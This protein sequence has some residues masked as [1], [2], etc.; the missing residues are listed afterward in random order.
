MSKDNRWKIVTVSAPG[1]V[2]MSILGNVQLGL[3]HP[4]N[5]GPSAQFAHA[6]CMDLLEKLKAE[7]V[8]T[9]DEAAKIYQDEM[10]AKARGWDRRG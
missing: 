7:G 4:E 3:R 1:L 2:W 10:I 5:N 6:A 8:L 9:A